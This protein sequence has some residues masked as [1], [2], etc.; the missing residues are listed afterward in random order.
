MSPF[1]LVLGVALLSMALRSFSHP[2]LHKLGSF[3]ILGTS[4]LIGYLLTGF[5][6]VG[7]VC[8]GSWLMLPWL[9]ILT[10]VR[11]M[12]L[13]IEKPLR[14]RTAPSRELFPMLGDLTAEFEEEGF[15][16]IED[17][18]WDW[19]D[20][21]QFFRLL[22]KPDERLLATICLVDQDDLAFYYLRIT[23][24]RDDGT[25]WITWNNPFSSPLKEVPQRRI[26]RVRGDFTVLDLIASHRAFL[27]RSGAKTEELTPYN[28][29]DI[30]TELQRELQA[31]IAHNIS[32]GVLLPEP[33]GKV[34]Y[35]WRGLFFLWVQF[36]RDFVRLS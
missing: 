22:Y 7:L 13:P 6:Q 1:L 15:E 26:N 11:R 5:W 24:R 18:G 19:E 35:S 2:V 33:E 3:C 21:K 29:E 23:S 8:S 4:F 31:Q 17:A 34:R 20:Q 16:Y 28:P 30:Q 14:H 27:A 25:A 32:A 12:R 10:R 9:E 36:L